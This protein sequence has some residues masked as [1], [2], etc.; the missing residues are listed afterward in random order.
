MAF[1]K[2][3]VGKD[4]RDKL[5]L[6]VNK[7]ANIVGST[8]G[9]LGRDVIINNNG[10]LPSVTN[11]GITVASAFNLED[12]VENLGVEIVR[13]ISAKTN[14]QAGDGTTTS[15]ILAD[16]M[17]KLGCEYLDKNNNTNP[18]NI[19]KGMQLA[20]DNANEIINSI[21]KP[22]ENY[23]D[24]YNIARIS[25]NNDNEI[26]KM[27]A[28][29]YV[30]IGKNGILTVERVHSNET[31]VEIQDGYKISSGFLPVSTITDKIKNIIEY[32]NGVHIM[33][34]PNKLELSK[35]L[36]EKVLPLANSKENLESVL[37]V[38][39][40]ID[41]D[42]IN[43]IRS[44]KLRVCL[45]SWPGVEGHQNDL[46]EDLSVY[47]DAKPIYNSNVIGY[48]DSFKSEHNKTVLINGK[49]T[50]ESIEE[51][52]E[53]LKLRLD[54]KKP[55]YHN[56]GL[57]DRIGYLSA[58]IAIMHLGAKS[59]IERGELYDRVE[60]AVKAVKS[61]IE[62]G[63][64]PGASYTF[65]K[66]YNELKCT[67]KNK[68]IINGFNIVKKSLIEPFNKI[69][70]NAG[71]NSK[72][73][74]KNIDNQIYD[75]KNNKYMKLEDCNIYDPANVIKMSIQNAVSVTSMILLSD[76]LIF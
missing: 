53:I 6:G 33:L 23:E 64:L 49:G 55:K 22:L 42:V 32:K 50:K 30:K 27:I 56:M 52:I 38:C 7:L 1:K 37:I 10:S 24:F 2:I 29:T 41:E 73:I 51:R 69:C 36:Y 40:N 75:V 21:S 20:V 26:G 16:S 12:E 62:L 13:S 11:D 28:D 48:C 63:I 8:I 68:D 47:I 15:C 34:C 65:I 3:Y 45:I 31:F 14:E 19:K 46:F 39:S 67:D 70:K 60:D 72:S 18:I 44:N 4:M 59:L 66:L 76:S 43:L 5:V 9:P 17:L 54:D 57:L 58:K 74:L 25:A 35:D 61:S 71:I